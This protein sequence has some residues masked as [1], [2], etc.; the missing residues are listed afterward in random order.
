M[1]VF[2]IVGWIL[3]LFGLLIILILNK[4]NKICNGSEKYICEIF[5]RIREYFKENSW[6]FG[7][8]LLIVGLVSL[9]MNK[10][11]YDNPQNQPSN[12]DD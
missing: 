2:G 5:I 9:V 7:F 3:S 11:Y 12:D 4:K 6:I 8:I 1:K 10:I